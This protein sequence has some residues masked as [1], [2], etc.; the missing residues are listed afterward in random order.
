MNLTH[1]CTTE[2]LILSTYCFCI[3]KN[4]F[5]NIKITKQIQFMGISFQEATGKTYE[6]TLKTATPSGLLR[7]RVT[8]EKKYIALG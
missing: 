1:F 6:E 4:D 8:T 7:S 5:L 3:L 2:L